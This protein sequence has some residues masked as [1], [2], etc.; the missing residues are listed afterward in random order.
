MVYYSMK[1]TPA[2]CNCVIYDQAVLAIITPLDE[3]RLIY[4]AEAYPLQLLTDHKNLKYVWTT[5]LL[6]WRWLQ[7]WEPFALF[8]YQIVYRPV[9]TNGK[10]NAMI[11]RV[12]DSPE[13]RDKTIKSRKQVIL[14]L[15][16]LPEQWHLL[17]DNSSAPGCPSRFNYMIK[18]YVTD[19]A[20]GNIQN[21]IWSNNV[22]EDVMITECAEIEGT[23]QYRGIL[24]VPYDD[25]LYW[26]LIQEYDATALAEHLDWGKT[27][28]SLH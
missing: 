7:W 4:T 10:V 23:M 15:K 13:R 3:C 9:Q 28:N 16:N 2:E 26:P 20:P 8:V 11:R 25:I 19:P 1:P 27:F 17:A 18:V 12:E 22:L 5:T 21:V 14:M 24:Y 6:N